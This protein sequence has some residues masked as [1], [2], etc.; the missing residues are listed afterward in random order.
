MS[1]IRSSRAFF[2]SSSFVTRWTVRLTS[3]PGGVGLLVHEHVLDERHRQAEYG[4]VQESPA[5]G[6]DAQGVEGSVVPLRR[7]L[8]AVA[9]Q[10]R[11][12]LLEDNPYGVFTGGDACRRSR[13]STRVA[14]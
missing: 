12:L 2:S 9:E 7:R 6:E 11:I 8:L 13:R 4:P 10:E 5:G 14:A 1:V 3:W